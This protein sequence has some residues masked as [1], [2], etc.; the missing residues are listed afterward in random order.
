MARA[1][2]LG[3]RRAMPV[4]SLTASVDLYCSNVS[5]P[6]SQPASHNGFESSVPSAWFPIQAALPPLLLRRSARSCGLATVYAAL[7]SFP[8]W[9]RSARM[10]QRVE[11][12]LPCCEGVYLQTYYFLTATKAVI[13][14]NAVSSSTP[15]NC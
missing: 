12:F 5:H 3:Q 10:K 13:P 4:Y 9:V 6:A 7:F 15:R 8:V 1:A 14:C 2:V 11:Y